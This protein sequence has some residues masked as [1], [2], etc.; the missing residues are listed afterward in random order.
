MNEVKTT[1]Q[2]PQFDADNINMYLDEL[3]MWQM[4]SEVD[5]KKQAL[6]VWLTLKKI[7]QAT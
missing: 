6:L 7:I 1:V 5:K 2:L 3:E 4:V